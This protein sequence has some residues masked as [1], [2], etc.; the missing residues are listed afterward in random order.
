MNQ[1]VARSTEKRLFF[2]VLLCALL[3]IVFWTQSRYPALNEKAMM[4]G[5]IQLE[6]PLGFEAKFPLTE[7]MGTLER[8]FFSTMNWINTNKKGMTFGILFAAAFLTLFGYLRRRSFNGGFAN[9]FLGLVIGAP[10]GVCANCAAPIGKGMYAAGVRAETAL[11]AMVASPTLNIIVLTMAF[12]LLPFYMAVA[13]IVLSLAVILVAVPLICR[14]LPREQLQAV[15]PPDVAGQVEGDAA[16]FRESVPAAFAEFLRS[17]AANLWFIVKTTVP[18]MLMAGF[19][20]AIAATL[21]P[22]DLVLGATFSLGVLVL[23]ALVGTFL[24]VPISF[25]VVVAG[26]LLAT[27]L[28]HGYVFA[29]MFTLGSVSVYSWLIVSSTISA[30]AAN[31]L[32]GVILALGVLGGAAANWYHGWQSDRALEMLLSVER[33]TLPAAEAQGTDARWQIDSASPVT[34][35]AVPFAPRS[36]PAETPFT[37]IEAS[38]MGIDKPL[39]FSMKDMWPPFWEGR[40]LATGDIDRDGDMDLVIA[41]TEAGLYIYHN[42]GAGRF[43]RS[44]DDIAPVADLDVFN[45]ALVDIDND[46]WLDLFLATYMDGNLWIRGDGGAFAMDDAR[47]VA[48]RADTPLT[49]ALSFGDV[50]GDGF[51]DAALGNWAAGWYRRI[52]GEESRNRVVLNEG[53]RMDGSRFADLPGLPGETLTMLLSDVNLDGHPDLLVGNDFELPDYLYHGDGQGGFTAVTRADGLIPHTT[54]TTM[55]IRTADLHNDGV[56]EIYFAQIAGRSSGVSGTLKM[57]DLDLYCDGIEDEAAQETCARNMAIKTWYRSGNQ[58]D[59]TYAGRCKALEGTLQAECKAMLIKDLAIQ[60]RDPSLC[61]L[62]PD[63]QAQPKVYCDIHFKPF[64]APLK[65]EFDKTLPQIMRANV[66]LT[67]KNGAYADTAGPEWLEVGGWSWDVKIADF[68]N[69]GWQ[70]VYI[71]NGTWVPNEVSPSNLFFRN[72]GDGRFVEAS[73]PFGLEDYLM[74]AA[75]AAIDIEGDGDLDIL[76]QPVNGPVV[77]F[78]NNAQAGGAVTVALRDGQGNSHGIGAR[79]SAELPDGPRMTRELT[80]G[81]GFM[82]FDEPVAHFGLGDTDALAALTIRWPD[83]EETRVEGPIPAGAA[84]T[85]TREAAALR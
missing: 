14:L 62:I 31:L 25:D 37:R 77:L 56:P 80:L 65:A 52:P 55:A 1:L 28:A 70:D 29:L 75:A 67:L 33:A 35:S 59:P 22:Q 30:R 27:G 74:T 43:S 69:D 8:I 58:F 64:V 7:Q 6:D 78:V 81:G 54:N 44:A 84:Y 17:F 83:G 48:N 68:D 82:S 4:S 2:A 49:M 47:P 40:S 21:M 46:G 24:P 15:P 61:A 9:S 73:G 57:Q 45:A 36:A 72:T 13:K 60:R 26:A 53:G 23:V 34:V 5:A 41:S 42:D 18:L 66:L 51:L 11:S 12:S 85:V 50:D 71:V 79:L 20:G 10:L 76:T 19:L 32:A 16:A 3:A 38:A 39:E 63:A